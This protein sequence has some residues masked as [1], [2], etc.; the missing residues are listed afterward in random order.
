MG[1]IAGA[2]GELIFSTRRNPGISLA[3][4]CPILG[5]FV[6]EDRHEPTKGHPLQGPHRDLRPVGFQPLYLVM[7]SLGLRIE[8]QRPEVIIGRHSQAEVRL[9]TPEISRRHCRLVFEQQQWR[10]YDLESL[11]GVF[12]NGE[13]MQEA[14]LHQGDQLQLGGFVFQI[15]H[16]EVGT[17]A[18]DENPREDV[19][20]SIAAIMKERPAS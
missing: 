17:A 7:D 20:E 19:L 4:Y 8:V 9:A 16:A 13:R 12:V 11:N 2:S 6:M 14:T 10:V 15:E 5:R 3:D 18:Q 1:A